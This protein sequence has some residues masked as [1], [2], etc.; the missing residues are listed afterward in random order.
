MQ[1]II[2]ERHPRGQPLVVLFYKGKDYDDE[3]RVSPRDEGIYR[4]KPTVHHPE[5][6]RGQKMREAQ[7]NWRVF[8]NMVL[9][10]K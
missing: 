5:S 6:G 7:N 3:A 10:D 8:S 9:E 4:S 1:G 2:D